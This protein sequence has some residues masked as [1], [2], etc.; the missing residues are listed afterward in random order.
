MK[1]ICTLS[2]KLIELGL[3]FSLIVQQ[4]KAVPLCHA[5]TKGDRKYSSYSFLTLALMRVSGER[6]ARAVL[7][8]RERTPDIMDRR[9]GGPQSWSGHR[10]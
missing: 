1:L 10:G 2:S 9:L 5:G 4:R 8:P 6:H 3:N 7:Y